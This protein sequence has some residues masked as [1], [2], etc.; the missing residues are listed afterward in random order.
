M[1]SGASSR[2]AQIDEM[3]CAAQAEG[4]GVSVMINDGAGPQVDKFSQRYAC[5]RSRGYRLKSLSGEEAARL[6]SLGGVDREAYWSDLL[7]KNGLS[8]AP[9][10]DAPVA[11][12]HGPASDRA[13]A[14]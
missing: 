10:P 6:K 1:R 5:L 2:D 11:A 3:D 8:A 7:V 13:S 12:A 14:Q 9:N 4:G